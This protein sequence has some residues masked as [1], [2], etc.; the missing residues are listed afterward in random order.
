MMLN[1]P[2]P[3]GNKERVLRDVASYAICIK[4]NRICETPFFFKKE[5]KSEGCWRTCEVPM[6]VKFQTSENP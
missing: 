3:R 4:T 6:T 2:P 5:L 1:Y